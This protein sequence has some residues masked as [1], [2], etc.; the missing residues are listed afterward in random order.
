MNRDNFVETSFKGKHNRNGF[1]EKKVPPTLITTTTTT[2]TWH[3]YSTKQSKYM[4]CGYISMHRND[5]NN[6]LK[7]KEEEEVKD[8]SIYIFF[9]NSRTFLGSQHVAAA[10]ELS[11]TYLKVHVVCRKSHTRLDA[12]HRGF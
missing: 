2:S 11:R 1:V 4:S 9:I 3:M 8:E 6:N 7:R 10:V 5:A 12:L